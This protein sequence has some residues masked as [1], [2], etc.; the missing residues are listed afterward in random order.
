MRHLAAIGLGYTA[1][2]L[3]RR[4]AEAREHERWQ[5]TGSSRTAEGA[6]R[7]RAK[8]Y[9]D[10]VFNSETPADELTAALDGVTHLLISAPPEVSGDPVLARLVESMA[11]PTSLEWVGFL[12]TIGVYGDHGGAWID[13]DTATAP[14]TE[15]AQRRLQAENDWLSFGMAHEIHV[16]VL[17]L[18]G[19]YGPTR[20]VF[21]R[22]RSGKAKRII[23]PG[24]VFNRMHVDDIAGV[25]DAAMRAGAGSSAIYN[26]SD[27]LPAAPEDPITFAAELM[28]VA[29]PQEVPFEDAE[30]SAM[31]RDFYSQSKRVSNKRIKAELGYDLIYP[32]YREGLRAIWSGMAK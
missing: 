4:L 17:R 12:S 27:D 22:L 7:I 3:A 15:R 14:P 20:S 30:M 11:P 25:I 1:E 28:G 9:R 26:L 24:Q 31:A 5:I 2:A 13:E 23:K 10:I 21:E 18:P 32:T 8:G 6:R 29:P 16:H 19:I